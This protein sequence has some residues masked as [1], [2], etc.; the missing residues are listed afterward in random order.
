MDVVTR[1][2]TT[3]DVLLECHIDDTWNVNGVWQLSWPR[4]G[5]RPVHLDE[6]PPHIRDTCG[7]ELSV[8]PPMTVG[9]SFCSAAFH[10]DSLFTAR[11]LTALKPWLVRP[12]KSECGKLTDRGSHADVF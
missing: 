1:T 12:V 10:D 2:N 6:I 8:E 5:F 11:E 7:L 4:T 3:L 9:L